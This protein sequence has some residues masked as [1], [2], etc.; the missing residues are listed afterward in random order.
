M[1]VC[2]ATSPNISGVPIGPQGRLTGFEIET[3]THIYYTFKTMV[4]TIG[5]RLVF[6]IIGFGVLSKDIF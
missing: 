3:P 4:V 6:A 1:G 5:K 2:T